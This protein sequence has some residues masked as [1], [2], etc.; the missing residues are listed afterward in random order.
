[1]VL[2][3]ILLRRVVVNS[4]AHRFYNHMRVYGVD[5]AV[6]DGRAWYPR[7]WQTCKTISRETGVA[8]QRVAAVMAVTSPRARW[9]TNVEAT[10]KLC[11]EAQDKSYS[12]SYNILGANAKKAVRVLESRY[13]SGIL[14]GP[15]VTAFYA[16]I[17]GDENSVTVDSLMSKAAGFGS[18]VSDAIREEVVT[19]VWQIGDVFGLSPRDAQAAVWCAYRGSDV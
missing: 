18:D 9:A 5:R 11:E 13:Y 4:T 19:S 17:L 15:K 3:L 10:A 12:Y 16:A 6:A 2:V 7:A 1:M 14:S 8:A